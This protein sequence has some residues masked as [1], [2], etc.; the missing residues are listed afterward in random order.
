LPFLFL[1]FGAFAQDGPYRNAI[2]LSFENDMFNKMDWYFS[3]GINIGTYHSAL[4]KSP[5]NR[6]LI[7]GRLREG[8]I[9]YYGLKLRQEI[10]TPRDLNHDEIL[11]GDH[12]YAATLSLSSEKIVNRPS[13]GLRF[14]SGLCLG[15]LGPLALGF[16]A[17]EFI[18][19]IT[20][21]EPP[22]GWNNQVGNDLML[23]YSLAVDKEIFRDDFS[24]FVLHGRGRLGTV[25]TDASAGF[26]VRMDAM[27]AYF[28]RLGPEDNRAVNIYF[29]L[30]GDI[31]F[32]G[33]DA[34]LQGGMLNRTSPYTIPSQDVRRMI[35]VITASAV[36]EIKCHQLHFYQNVVS[37]R[38]S[39]ASWHAWLG[40]SYRYWW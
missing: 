24:Q 16:H 36:L 8:D 2:V 27:P 39:K 6:I 37:P 29:E 13:E 22:H 23:N 19:K 18:H 1:G 14:T 20:P 5:V 38:F 25:Y 3:N 34:S 7:P 10:Y 28:T 33:Y 15:V 30:G 35:G 40:I 11:A 12:P 26:R 31:R 17:Q 4:G 21:S 9:V 32:V